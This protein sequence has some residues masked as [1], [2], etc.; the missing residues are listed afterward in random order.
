MAGPIR[1]RRSPETW[2][3]D[4]VEQR[5]HQPLDQRFGASVDGP[6]L[7][8]PPEYEAVRLEMDNGDLALL[9]WSDECAYWLGNTETPEVLWQTDKVT[10]DEAPYPVARWAQRELLSTLA[11]EAP[12]LDAYPYVSWYFLPVLFSKDGRETTRTFFRDHAAGFPDADREAGLAFYES[13]LRRTDLDDHRYT[14]AAKLGTSQAMD[15][16]RM[17]ATMAEF[18]AAKLLEDAGFSYRPEIELSSGHALDYAA[19]TPDNR[20]LLVEVTR[21]EAPGRRQAGTPAAAVRETV[22]SKTSDQLRSHPDALLFVDCSSFRDDEWA[23]LHRDTPDVGY[24]PALVYRLRP[25]G[26]VSGYATGGVPTSLAA[27]V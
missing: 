17:R 14:M 6:R 11:D 13:L 26:R 3:R 16:V 1:F 15:L 22:A 18:N 27:L 2:H 9:A 20:D 10:F 7:S 5:L 8:P 21:P 23:A 19:G 24:Q 12:W 25:D 4:R